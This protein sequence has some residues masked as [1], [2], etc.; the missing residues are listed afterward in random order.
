MHLPK[1]LVAEFFGMFWLVVGGC[2]AAALDA[3]YPRLGIG[4]LG[5]A[6]AFGLTLVTMVGV[7]FFLPSR[8]G[9]MLPKVHRLDKPSRAREPEPRSNR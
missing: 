1:K 2:G 5:V 6:L 7:R 9:P 3:A 4:F 8:G